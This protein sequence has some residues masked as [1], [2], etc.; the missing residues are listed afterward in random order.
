M[1]WVGLVEGLWWDGE[2]HGG[3]GRTLMEVQL[4]LRTSCRCEAPV[5]R[6]RIG[7]TRAVWSRVSS[8]RGVFW[9]SL[10]TL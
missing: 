3:S 2:V 8:E 4:L 1:G 5:L 6:R 7:P 10:G 9:V